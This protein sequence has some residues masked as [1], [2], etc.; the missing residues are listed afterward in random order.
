[1]LYFEETQNIDHI[2]LH[3]NKVFSHADTIEKVPYK[4]LEYEEG[5]KIILRCNNLIYKNKKLHNFQLEELIRS[6]PDLT[7]RAPL[8]IA[9]GEAISYRRQKAA[10]T[11]I[12]AV[13]T[14]AALNFAAIYFLE[15]RKQKGY[16][17]AAIGFA[18]GAGA[19]FFIALRKR[20]ALKTVKK[21]IAEL[22]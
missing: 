12:S 9:Y 4:K 11:C 22:Y 5:Q 13:L 16:S 1:L 15:E 18:A 2:R 8:L 21:G 3:D 19:T 6:Y 7:K 14:Y 10:Y 17:L 20:Q